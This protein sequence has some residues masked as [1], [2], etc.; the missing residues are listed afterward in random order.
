MGFHS[1]DLLL[2]VFNL[3]MLVWI[4]TLV[5]TTPTQL[6]VVLYV[7]HCFGV[8]SL[9]YTYVSQIC[10]YD[11]AIYVSPFFKMTSLFEKLNS[12]I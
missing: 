9:H 11:G 6:V 3:L 10:E 4:H 2:S 8:V 1:F 12:I 7:L 5:L